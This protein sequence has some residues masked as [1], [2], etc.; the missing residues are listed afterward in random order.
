MG[1]CHS[2]AIVDCK[3]PMSDLYYSIRNCP[4]WYGTESP[5]VDEYRAMS[6]L[7]IA[8]I[9]KRE[10]DRLLKEVNND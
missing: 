6:A 5:K 9:G 1:L 3:Q 2:I 8:E 10:F 4:F 7:L